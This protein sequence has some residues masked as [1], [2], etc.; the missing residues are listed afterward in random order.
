MFASTIRNVVLQ[1]LT[2]MISR[3]IKSIAAAI[4]ALF[5]QTPLRKLCEIGDRFKNHLVRWGRAGIRRRRH[6]GLA[7][8][9]DD[10]PGNIARE[11]VLKCFVNFG[12]R[13]DSGLEFVEFEAAL[14]V[15]FDVPRK[16]NSRPACAC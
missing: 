6:M 12:E 15:H 3:T 16:V 14:P 9:L 7:L 4:S 8:R 1:F 11:H 5:A 10:C 13:P 2:D